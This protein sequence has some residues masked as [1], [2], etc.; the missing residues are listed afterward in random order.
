MGAHGWLYTSTGL[1]YFENLAALMAK[2]EH[3]YPY[4]AT[5]KLNILDYPRL[6]TSFVSIIYASHYITLIEAQGHHDFGDSAT[7]FP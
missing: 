1:V 6:S 5:S 7:G 2:K 4:T 3:T